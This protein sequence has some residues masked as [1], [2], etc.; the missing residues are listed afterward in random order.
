MTPYDLMTALI[1]DIA[2]AEEAVRVAQDR[3]DKLKAER[4]ALA[5]RIAYLTPK[6]E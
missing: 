1:R 3:L 6:P 4:K 2:E 5:H